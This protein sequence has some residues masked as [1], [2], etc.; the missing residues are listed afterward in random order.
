[1]KNRLP[2]K[3][4]KIRKLTSGNKTGDA[5]GI[6]IPAIYVKKYGL[7]DKLFK[8]SIRKNGAF[9]IHTKLRGV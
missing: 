5:Y 8:I 9:M 2:R 3:Q 7:Q 6:T 4:H 1:M